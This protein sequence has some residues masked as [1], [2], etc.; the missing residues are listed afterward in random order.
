MAKDMTRPNRFDGMM[1]EFCAGMGWCGGV[2]DGRRWR[3]TDF[4]PDAGFVSADDFVSW[5]ILAE[6]L[7]PHENSSGMRKTKERLKK[8]FLKHME[9]EILTVEELSTGHRQL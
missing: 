1:N 2:R 9:R 8:V 3:V 7:D 6:G 5:L 4:I